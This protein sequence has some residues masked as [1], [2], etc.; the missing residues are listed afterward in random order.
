MKLNGKN[1][2]YTYNREERL[3]PTTSGYCLNPRDQALQFRST[4][5]PVFIDSNSWS[6]NKI[7]SLIEETE[8]SG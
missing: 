5:F 1:G 2:L 4:W 7:R 6:A 8:I 3:D